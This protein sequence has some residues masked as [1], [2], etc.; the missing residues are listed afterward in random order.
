MITRFLI[1][2]NVIGYLWEVSVAGPG[3]LWASAVRT[4]ACSACSWTA[5]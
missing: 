1:V 2:L 3:M 4:P 5:R